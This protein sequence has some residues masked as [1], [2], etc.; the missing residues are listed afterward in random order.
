MKNRDLSTQRQLLAR[1]NYG[2]REM[3]EFLSNLSMALSQELEAKDL[4]S[5]EETDSLY[6]HYKESFNLA[7]ETNA[8]TY[9]QLS[10]E[11]VEMES[12]L[13]CFRTK[14]INSGA[15]LFSSAFD[16]CGALRVD[17]H[18]ALEHVFEL[19]LIDGDSVRLLDKSKTSG[20]MVDSYENSEKPGEEIY[21]LVIWGKEWL[22]AI[23]DC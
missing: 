21:E 14:V 20:L 8:A 17:L 4:L 1:K 23:K 9:R 15:V 6:D 19:I 5:L 10:G 11:K 22:S 7:M 16:Y 12:K 3:S 13:S 18:T 2:R